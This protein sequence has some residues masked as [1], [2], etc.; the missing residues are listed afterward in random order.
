MGEDQANDMVSGV[1]G[2]GLIVVGLALLVVSIFYFLTLQRTMD[3]LTEPNRPFPGAL[4]WLSLIPVAGPIWTCV[5]TIML[6]F[7]I[8]K[9]FEQAGRQDHEQGGSTFSIGM[10]VCLAL[11]WIPFVN[12]IALPV[13]VVFWI[14]YWVK[15]SALRGKM[16]VRALAAPPAPPVL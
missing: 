1:M 12:F 13:Y 4:I 2:L 15:I 16:P 6:S 14:I 10:A 5:Y 7:A 11:C 9:D 8:K 3:K